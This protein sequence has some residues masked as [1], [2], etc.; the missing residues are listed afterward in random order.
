MYI[1]K[2]PELWRITDAAHKVIAKHEYLIASE[3]LMSQISVENHP[4]VNASLYAMIAVAAAGFKAKMQSSSKPKDVMKTRII[5][6]R[7]LP[8]DHLIT[9][10]ELKALLS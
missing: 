10:E 1:M 3:K 5:D 8:K 6:I 2:E 4:L 7:G 9:A